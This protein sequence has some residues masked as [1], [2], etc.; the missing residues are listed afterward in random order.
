LEDLD[1]QLQQSTS[2]MTQHNSM[3]VQ[4]CLDRLRAGE[5][6][7]RNELLQAASERL[8]QLARVM[9]NDFPR[10]RRWEQTDDVLQNALL[11]PCRALGGVLPASVRDFYRLATLQIRR[12]LIDLVRHNYGPEGQGL[13]HATNAGGAEASQSKPPIYE[14]AMSDESPDRLA[15]WTD[16]HKEVDRLPEEER[17]VF[18]LLWYQGMKQTEA[19]ALLNVST[20]TIKRRWQ[21]AC[22]KLHDSLK[23][24]LPGL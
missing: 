3:Y 7:A 6:G 15:A 8:D 2:T 4:G 16:F 20:K 21:S 13:K 23:D 5:E 22:L 1:G 12:E 18:D 10:L 11:R 24:N 19:A 17:E 14:Q 9:L